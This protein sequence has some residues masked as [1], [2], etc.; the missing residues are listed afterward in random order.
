MSGSII[1]L[2]LINSLHLSSLL[3]CIVPRQDSCWMEVSTCH[4]LTV[5]R[6]DN[7]HFHHT[8]PFISSISHSHNYI[9]CE[10]FVYA[11][12][13]ERAVRTCVCSAARESGVRVCVC[14]AARESGVCSTARESGV[15]VCVVRPR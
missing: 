13:P 2:N 14:S 9:W 7:G 8:I 15:R 4:L 6:Y 12:W 3:L 5:S 1:V 10:C 11:V